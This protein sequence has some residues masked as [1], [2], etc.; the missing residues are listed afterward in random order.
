MD[1]VKSRWKNFVKK[2]H[3]YLIKAMD[4]KEYSAYG[5][6]LWLQCSDDLGVEVDLNAVGLGIDLKAP[7]A[8]RLNGWTQPSL[9]LNIYFHSKSLE[10]WKRSV[11]RGG[12]SPRAMGCTTA[13]PIDSA[14]LDIIC[15]TKSPAKPVMHA[16]AAQVDDFIRERLA[17]VITLAD[18]HVMLKS[19]SVWGQDLFS[20][21]GMI[22]LVVS[23]QAA[24]ERAKSEVQRMKSEL[25]PKGRDFSYL[26][27]FVE[28]VARFYQS[29]S[30]A[31][32]NQS[33]RGEN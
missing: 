32:M 24:V 9:V 14:M 8:I 18:L 30:D 33:F 7:A 19:D 29:Q 3:D 15:N 1:A 12:G 31:S 28:G 2:L 6:A 10:E 21:V 16:V 17:G 5:K 11:M 23:P 20:E 22:A 13:V 25:G 26:D 27:D 4:Y